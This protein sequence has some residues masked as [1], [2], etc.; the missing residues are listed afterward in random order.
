[1]VPACGPATRTGGQ[2]RGH[3]ATAEFAGCW[4]H[5]CCAALSNEQQE[6]SAGQ[7]GF[8]LSFLDGPLLHLTQSI[9][10]V[11]LEKRHCTQVIFLLKHSRK[12]RGY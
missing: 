11:C 3:Q 7:L 8:V 5:G 4:L 9:R 12:A 1:M 10:L 2:Q 6:A